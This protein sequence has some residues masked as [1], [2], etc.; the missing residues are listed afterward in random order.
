MKLSIVLSTQPAS[1]SALAY[2]GNLDESIRRIRLLGYDGVELAV[3]DPGLLDRAR[4]KSLLEGSGLIVSAIGTG[5][6]FGEEGLSFTHNDS[7]VRGRAIERV[8]SHVRLAA[9]LGALVIIGLV[10]GRRGTDVP[11]R[12]AEEW[13]TEAVRDCAAE[14]RT[15]N[16]AIEPINRYETDLINTVAS[17]LEFVD[18]LGLENVGL[19]LDTFHMNIEE[20]SLTE[21]IAASRGRLMHVHVADSNRWSPGSGHIDFRSVFE[22]LD[23]IGYLGFISAEILPLPDPDSAATNTIAHIRKLAAQPA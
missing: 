22:T 5:Q 13:M 11:E 3:R 10:R 19:L 12:K 20:P 9:D 7:R 21:S 8:K 23:E 2:K 14:N 1:F 18:K 6:A 16:L 4:L 17:G 15:V